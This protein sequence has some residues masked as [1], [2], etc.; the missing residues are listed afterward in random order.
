MDH[1]FMLD[2]KQ[3]L[4]EEEDAAMLKSLLNNEIPRNPES[5][6]HSELEI[7]TRLSEYSSLSTLLDSPDFRAFGAEEYITD[8]KEMF[9]S[10]PERPKPKKGK[11]DK[12]DWQKKVAKYEENYQIVQ[13][14]PSIIPAYFSAIRVFEY[15]VSEL[16]GVQ[17]HRQGYEVIER[18]NWTEWWAQ[19]DRELT[20]E[21]ET[22][23]GLTF[24]TSFDTF[25]SEEN[26]HPHHQDL[27]IE[28]KKKKS[29]KKPAPPSIRLPP[30]PHK[31]APRGPI[32]ESQLFSPIRWEVHFVNLT[33][34]NEE[35]EKYPERKWDY[36]KDFFKME[37]SSDAAPYNMKDLTVGTWLDLGI[38]IGKE[39]T[40]DKT[41]MAELEIVDEMN[42]KRGK[43]DKKGKDSGDAKKGG[44][45]KDKE[46]FWDVFLRR[47][48]VNCGHKLEFG[49]E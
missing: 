16:A 32:Y 37:Y 18:T 41:K 14:A 10:I 40:V 24:Q 5:M 28:K 23:E 34:I 9:E 11:K 25:P 38:K 26:L 48:F 49:D 44:A 36:G 8:L 33:A 15:N 35:H 7:L 43:G 29:K 39:K 3:A 47:A 42:R 30:G 45:R 13:V 12:K 1:F 46:T 31:S 27:S 21:K 17:F 6:S 2:A 4:K 19:M 20:E 22:S